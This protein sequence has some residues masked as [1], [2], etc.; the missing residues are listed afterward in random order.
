MDIMDDKA[1][2]IN[3]AKAERDFLSTTSN[4]QIAALLENEAIHIDGQ[5]FHPK[6]QY[7]MEP[8]RSTGI[9][10]AW[11]KKAENWENDAGLRLIREGV[12]IDWR[13]RAIDVSAHVSVEKITIPGG[14]SNILECFVSRPRRS[15]RRTLP[16]LLYFHGG[17]FLIG[18]AMALQPHAEL[19]SYICEAIVVNV[20]YR[21]APKHKF[22]AAFL[23]AYSAYDWCRINAEKLGGDPDRIAAAGDS[24]GGCLSLNVAREA[25]EQKKTPLSALLLYYPMVDT[26]T[27]Y[28]SF[29]LFGEG[30]G[31][32]NNFADTFIR[33]VYSDPE[34][35]DHKY[36]RPISWTN[37]D[38]LPPTIIATAGFDIIRDQ[39]QKMAA[40]ISNAKGEIHV[41]NCP[42]LNHS[43]IKNAGVI[44]DAADACF[45]T[46]VLLKE[47]FDRQE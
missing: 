39:G 18:S 31:L 8:N 17:G 21:L 15:S 40:L 36:L 44:D 2:A 32:D 47:I 42:S 20:S 34:D 27:D 24:A 19:L 10:E 45:S 6:L 38:D 9:F 1:K 5:Y 26:R 3:I 14:D 4:A 33:M 22:P 28:K 25:F 30:F 11:E 41:R 37:L 16:I 35:A 43:F 46:A 7:L 23:D 12:N 29:E 13:A